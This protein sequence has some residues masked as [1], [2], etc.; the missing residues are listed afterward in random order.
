M[1]LLLLVGLFL[2]GAAV[3]LIARGAGMARAR[4][5]ENL[6][7][8]DSYGFAVVPVDPEASGALR[9]SLETVVGAIGGVFMRH[10]G[11]V[12]E[13]ELRT[14]L[15]AAGMYDL[16]PRKFLGYQALCAVCMPA[17]WGWLALAGTTPAVLGVLGTP[18]AV[19]FGWLSPTLFVRRR[20]RRRLENIDYALPELI[21]LLIVAV[22]A[23]VGFN[24]SLRIASERLQP[25][26]RDELRLALQEQSM[27]LSTNEALRNMQ[28]R[29]DT[30]RVHAF[31]RAILQSETLGVS[32]GHI[33]RSLA[34]E[35]RKRRRQ[36]AEERAQKAPT[37]LLFPL[38]FFI[39]PAMFVVLL[40]PA[41][42]KFLET[43]SGS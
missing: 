26:L 7:R 41:V 9:E 38:I 32:I 40:A 31:V 12:R 34:I 3:A 33:L 13:A 4:M 25:P 42:M 2:A 1:T 43:M 6:S 39:F 5:S 29:C 8:I 16:S 20:T 35:M 27:G 18:I 24:A 28:A 10:F 23:G 17:T 37:K 19:V 22:E 36:A 15:M 30:P 21:D 11:R 14:M